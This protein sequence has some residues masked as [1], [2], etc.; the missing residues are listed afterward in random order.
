MICILANRYLYSYP[1][2]MISYLPFSAPISG[3]V[4]WVTYIIKR[5]ELDRWEQDNINEAPAYP[6]VSNDNLKK[7][8]DVIYT[9]LF[10]FH[11][12]DQSAQAEKF[13]KRH[14]DEMGYAD[15]EPELIGG[16]GDN[17]P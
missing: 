17:P 12:A 11:Y 4:F 9:C 16:V 14:L 7:L 15:W 2:V 6:P 5:Q 3:L 1:V 13:L 10:S 8:A